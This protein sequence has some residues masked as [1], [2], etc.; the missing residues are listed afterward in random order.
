MALAKVKKIYGPPGTGKTTEL[1]RLVTEHIKK[2]TPPERIAYLSHTTAARE[3]VRSRVMKQ[4]PELKADQFVNFRTIHSI[5]MSLLGYK[6]VNVIDIKDYREFARE[7]GVKLNP[8]DPTSIDWGDEDDDN[9]MSVL[10]MYSVAVNRGIRVED[11]SPDL[12][13]SDFDID[14]RELFLKDWEAYKRERFKVDFD[15]MLLQYADGEGQD[16]DVD[17]LFVDEGQDLSRLQWSIIDR[18]KGRVKLVYIAG[19]DDQTIFTWGGADE[20]GFLNYPCHDE[21]VLHQSYRVPEVIGRKADT[22]IR[23]VAQR[24]EKNVKWRD[25]PGSYEHVPMFVE[26]LNWQELMAKYGSIMFISRHNR[27][28]RRAAKMLDELGVPYS[29]KGESLQNG[30]EANMVKAFVNIR[31]GGTMSH[32]KMA[33]L[34]DKLGKGGLARDFRR[35]GLG[36]GTKKMAGKADVPEVEWDREDWEN[37]FEGVTELKR[38]ALRKL[39]AVVNSFGIEVLGTDPIVDLCTMH[40]SKGREADLVIIDPDCSARIHHRWADTEEIRLSYV[41]ITRALRDVMVLA[42]RGKYSI[43]HFEG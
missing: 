30:S 28:I 34:L 3:V 40:G 25:A 39:R 17:I 22:I 29:M 10:E 7:Y 42:P 41:A 37:V 31:N 19:D 32:T 6:K 36:F 27:G 13:R 16:L 14:R 21:K 5:C 2:G 20:F 38:E 35:S 4:F 23:Q 24:K 11:L 26:D 15:D 8:R 12:F 1:L 9:Y 33:S 43:Q 18:F